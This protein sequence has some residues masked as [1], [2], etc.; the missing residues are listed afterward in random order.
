MDILLISEWI[1]SPTVSTISHL[2]CLHFLSPPLQPIPARIRQKFDSAKLKFE[3]CKK[4]FS[5]DNLSLAESNFCRILAGIGWSGGERKWRQWRWE[6]V[7][8]VGL[9]IHSEINSISKSTVSFRAEFYMN[10]C[11]CLQHSISTVVKLLYKF[12]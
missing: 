10:D 9:D 8:T 7:E 4:D 1:S 2:H 5:M 11:I 12:C 6:I 3:F